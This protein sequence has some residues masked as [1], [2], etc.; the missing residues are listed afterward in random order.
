MDDTVPT[1][2]V[3]SA[4]QLNQEIALAASQ[5]GLQIQ[6]GGEGDF[7][8]EVAL[9][10]EYPGDRELAMGRPFVGGS[11]KY[12]WEVLRKQGLDRTRVWATN[13]V[14]RG[15]AYT[16][17][18]DAADAAGKVAVNRGELQHWQWLLHH[19][20]GHLPNLRFIVVLGSYA[21]R[22]V[23]GEDSITSW[24]G[25]VVERDINGRTYTVVI[26]NNPAYAMRVPVYDPVFRMHIAKLQRVRDGKYP[27]HKIESVINPSPLDAVAWIDRLHD[28]QLPTA[29]DIETIANETACI[30]LANNPHMG[31]CISFRSLSENVYSASDERTVRVAIQRFVDDNRTRLVAQNGTF[32][33]YWLA[34]KDRIV[35]RRIWADTLLGHHT[36]YPHLPHNLGFLTSQYTTHP[37]YKDDGKNWREGGDIDQFWRYNVTDCCITL[38]AWRKIQQ[39][40]QAQKLEDF[41]FNHVMRL[42]PKLVRMTV[43]G[44]L[45]DT[46]VKHHLMTTLQS[47]VD[48]IREQFTS[49]VRTATGDPERVVNPAS[50]VQLKRLFFQDLRLVGRGTSTNEENRNRMLAHPRTS[51]DAKTILHLLDQFREKE[52]FRGTY[53]EFELDPDNRCRSEYKQFGVAST[54]G[55]LSSTQTMWGS[56]MNLQNQTEKSKE[57]FIADPGYRLIYFDLAQAEA[58]I[59]AYHWGIQGLIDNFELAAGGVDVHR[60]NAARIFGLDIDQIPKQ[61][62]DAEKRPTLRYLGKRCVHGLNYRMAPDKLASTCNIP[63]SQAIDAWR[64]YH[65][66]FPMRRA[67]EAVLDVAYKTGEIWTPLGRRLKFLGRLPDRTAGFGSQE[68]TVLDGIIAF[69]PQ[70]TIGEKVA[71]V[72]YLCED[73]EDWPS[74]DAR[75]LLNVHDALIGL[76]RDDDDLATHCMR[77][78]RKH[79]EAPIAGVGYDHSSKTWTRPWRISIPAD[80]AWSAPDASGLHRWSNLQKV[81]I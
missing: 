61:D 24:A 77:I 39:E 29:L 68:A 9:I 49:A 12:L 65:K 30:G 81:K 59:V 57:M 48:A 56:G 13:V 50:P 72:Q 60:A 66:V 23:A 18:A 22:A 58:R 28:E 2:A 51:E 8:A 31:M 47:E 3:T 40:L 75:I 5:V 27:G 54:P 37:F 16:G 33:S 17:D 26:C 42:Q 62:W 36:L 41:F 74:A 43:N 80:V 4:A 53:A 38:A 20:L 78:M 7:N 64:A 32:D 46:N 67:W 1:G 76:V 73:D 44:I 79:A 34:Y 15:I 21:L 11:G 69:V 71:S 19:E 14:K 63:V 70:S 10:G 6:V 35:V 25:S 45:C 52:K 55:R